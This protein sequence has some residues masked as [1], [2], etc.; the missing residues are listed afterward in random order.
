MC[1]TAHF[2]AHIDIIAIR[3]LV[4]WVHKI[5]GERD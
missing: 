1:L 5:F 4:N 2:V 3:K